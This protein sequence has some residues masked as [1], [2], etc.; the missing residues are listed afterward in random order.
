MH[1]VSLGTAASRGI[2]RRRI[3]PPQPPPSR[4]HG[5]DLLREAW[6]LITRRHRRM[7]NSST[8]LKHY[9]LVVRKHSAEICLVRCSQVLLKS[10]SIIYY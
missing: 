1:D 7:G 9:A 3:P 2:H 4:S 5:A 8:S 6:G 10:V